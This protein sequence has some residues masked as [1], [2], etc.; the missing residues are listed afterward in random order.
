MSNK[1]PKVDPISWVF[2][3]GSAIVLL[4][5]VYVLVT[6]LI[7][8]INKNSVK[9]EIDSTSLVA[10]ASD[11]LK[12]IGVSSTSDAP[13][14]V[15]S[16]SARSGKEVYDKVCAACHATGVADS[17]LF[18]DKAAW[19][20]RVATGMDALMTTAI[21]GKGA[22]P[23]RAGQ[24]IGDDELRAAILY[25][26][27]EAG[28]D[29]GEAPVA[30]APAKV[31]EPK[32][33]P[34]TEQKMEEKPSVEE[35]DKVVDAVKD[36]PTAPKAPQQP[37]AP[38]IAAVVVAEAVAASETTT[39]VPKT[40]SLYF[41]VGSTN[42]P[43]NTDVSGL[44]DFIKNNDKAIAIISG[45]NDASGS[46]D[47]NAEISKKRAQAVAKFLEESGLSS[48]SIKLEK[49]METTGTGSDKEARR[50]EVSI[51]MSEQA[52]AEATPDKATPEKAPTEEKSAPV[53]EVAAATAAVVETASVAPSAETLE[54]GKAV[55]SRTC[56][57]CHATGVAGSPKLDDKAAWAPRIATGMEALY[58]TSLNGKGAMPPKGGNTSL[59]DEDVK[60]AVDYMVSVAK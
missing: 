56:F 1:A 44:I 49:P 52:T 59:P 24:N 2:F 27:K 11:N 40:V 50:V 58:A 32:A 34:V 19:E 15:A 31:E 60:A 22:M 30:E 55:Y 21:N 42:L 3:I 16:T 51:R 20:P 9:G 29:L 37:E 35:A 25:M 4:L 23:A 38:V 47:K 48:E 53:A 13:V 8:T 10:A 54:K 41:D 6:S 39:A 12:P 5:A 26:T 43:E 57:A 14:V 7:N 18:G 45:F 46:A 36:T 33:E 17:P 28:F